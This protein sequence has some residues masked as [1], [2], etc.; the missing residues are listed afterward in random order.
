M[1]KITTEEL[2]Q[3]REL[4]SDTQRLVEEYS[5]LS[6]ELALIKKEHGVVESNMLRHIESQ[7]L[8]I[9][10]LHE[11]YGEGSLDIETGEITS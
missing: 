2:N 8:V 4:Q 5:K 9:Q 6:V 10:R 7:Q 1:K 11:K 3:L